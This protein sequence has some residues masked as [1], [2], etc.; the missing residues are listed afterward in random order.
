MDNKFLLTIGIP[1]YNRRDNVAERIL[2]LFSCGLPSEVKILVIDNASTDGT[3]SHLKKILQ[4]ISESYPKESLLI[5]S[6]IR[7]LKNNFNLGYAGNFFRLFKECETEYLLIDSDEDAIILNNIK[8][9]LDFIKRKNPDFIS[10]QAIID[11]S[12]YRG[13]AVERR[14]L[15]EEYRSASNYLSGL[16]FRVSACNKILSV[17]SGLESKN[18]AAMVYPQVLLASYILLYGNCY[19]IN[20]AITEKKQQLPS[21]I[22]DIVNGKYYHLSARFSQ[23]KGFIEF[24]KILADDAKLHN[25]KNIVEKLIEETQFELFDTIRRAISS[26]SV[27]L[28]HHFDR[29][30]KRSHNKFMIVKNYAFKFVVG[31]LKNPQQ[32]LIKTVAKLRLLTLT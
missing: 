4:D 1:T 9:L 2:E 5:S 31:I 25:K 21:Y 32:T 6:R 29:G 15:L 16:T 18:S 19:W 26:E 12:I 10:P 14:V 17:I 28:L 13:L 11:N 3:Q 7:I 23:H 30:A 22:D 8:E 20:L 27:E 24:F